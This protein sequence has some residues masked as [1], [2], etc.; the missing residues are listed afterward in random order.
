M[1]GRLEGLR[2]RESETHAPKAA[3]AHRPSRER[4]R[5]F[6]EEYK[7]RRL[8]EATEARSVGPAKVEGE[9]GSR[10]RYL[11]EYLRWLKPHWLGVGPLFL[12]ALVAAGLQMV[13][14]L[15]MRYIID[16]VLLDADLDAVSR[17]TR[18]NLVGA[19]FL[20][21][22][23]VSNVISVLRNYQQRLLNAHV[24]LTLRKALF[25][26]LVRLPLASLSAMKTGGILSRLTG[27]INTTTGLLQ[28]AIVSPAISVVRL[29]IAVSIL[30]ALNWRL[31]ARREAR[32]GSTR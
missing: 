3:D 16:D 7:S 21:V 15:F 18:L 14:P 17:F 25:E 27:D 20:A 29:L 4:Y 6:V 28:M 9:G 22:I 19:T 32:M 8:N 2:V 1:S 23:V 30:L 5:D 12:L 10:R 11:R 13:E 31:A 24:M 26:R